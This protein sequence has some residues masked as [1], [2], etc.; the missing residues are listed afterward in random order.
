M[1]KIIATRLTNT[2]NLLVNG[3]NG[4]FDET[5]QSTISTRGNVVYT[6]LLD[7]VTNT[8]GQSAMKHF[9]S[10]NLQIAGIF[11]EVTGMVVTRNLVL[12]LCADQHTSYT[13]QG[14]AMPAT[15]WY[16][17]SGQISGNVS[18]YGTLVSS[19]T[20]NA[21]NGG[22]LVFNGSSQYVTFPGTTTLGLDAHDKTMTAWIY[23][24]SYPSSPISLVDKENGSQG[25][26]FWINSS[27]KLWYWPQANNDAVD[28]GSLSLTTN[29]WNHAAVTWNNSTNTA[30]FYYNGVFSSSV[31][32]AG[33]EVASS[34]STPLYIAWWGRGGTSQYYAGRIAEIQLYNRVLSAAEILNNF[35]I[36]APNFGLATQGL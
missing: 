4:Y 24:T 13:G 11:D 7:E 14:N 17:I 15:N 23:P 36:G 21:S 35:N 27:G 31:T 2:G 28:T 30:S 8:G 18:L 3:Y 10:G 34:T 12:N 33:G 20:F 16:D 1:A 19:P 29:A 32:S 6:A 25:W 9:P 22:S 26:A 5:V